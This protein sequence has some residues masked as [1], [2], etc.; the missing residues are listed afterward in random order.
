MFNKKPYPAE[1]DNLRVNNRFLRIFLSVLL[2]VILMMTWALLRSMGNERTIIVPPDIHKS[3]W[4]NQETVS[5]EYLEQMAYFITGLMLTVTPETVKYQGDTLM[6]YVS[7]EMRGQMKTIIANNADKMTANSAS[8]IFHPATLQFGDSN[9]K[10][11]VVVTGV[12]TTFIADKKINDSS[13]TYLIAFAYRSG[14]ISLQIFKEVLPN[15][16]FNE[17]SKPAADHNDIIIQP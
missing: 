2:V 6:K 17:N 13:K 12:L 10:M 3:F 7:P 5:N 1:I 11:K 4:V 8:T 15:D 9:N 14:Q 16:P